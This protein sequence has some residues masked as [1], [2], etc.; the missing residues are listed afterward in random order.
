[1]NNCKLA[2]AGRKD[3][4]IIFWAQIKIQTMSQVVVKITTY[5][6]YLTAGADWFPGL[7]IKSDAFG[8]RGRQYQKQDHSCS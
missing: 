2:Y 6:D 1:M 4:S 7:C 8:L 3:Q 5:I